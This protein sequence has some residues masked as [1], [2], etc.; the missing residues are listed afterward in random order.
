MLFENLPYFYTV[1]SILAIMTQPVPIQNLAFVSNF[2]YTTSQTNSIGSL[3]DAKLTKMCMAISET[4]LIED[5]ENENDSHWESFP[6]I[7]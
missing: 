6:S 3:S 4:S 1:P 2:Q 5:W 7:D